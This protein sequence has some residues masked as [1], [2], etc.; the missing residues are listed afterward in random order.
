MCS[1]RR[2]TFPGLGLELGRTWLT[3]PAGTAWPCKQMNHSCRSFGHYGHAVNITVLVSGRRAVPF[4]RQTRFG[5]GPDRK[6]NCRVYTAGPAFR[7]SNQQV[8]THQM[9]LDPTPHVDGVS[10]KPIHQNF[11][12]L[13]SAAH[14][15][16]RDIKSSQHIVQT[17]CICSVLL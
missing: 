2:H 12:V 10:L 4:R 8:F 13:V 6:R 16:R 9:A 1:R 11:G 3:C 5:S 17:V 14:S 7:K 15:R